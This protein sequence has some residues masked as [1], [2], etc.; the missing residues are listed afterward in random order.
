MKQNEFKQRIASSLSPSLIH[1]MVV[2]VNVK[3]IC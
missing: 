3:D 1:L 2:I